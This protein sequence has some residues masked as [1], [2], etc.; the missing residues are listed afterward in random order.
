[1]C[2]QTRQRRLEIIIVLPMIG[3]SSLEA[4]RD[5]VANK[6]T[7]QNSQGVEML[8]DAKKFICDGETL[9]VK[10]FLMGEDVSEL[11]VVGKNTV[12]IM[13][14]AQDNKR[15]QLYLCCLISDSSLKKR[16]KATN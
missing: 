1:M 14:P 8:L 9:V 12:H 7:T 2:N 13:L 15:L 16:F 3:A 6:N 4:D 10:E 5:M 11:A